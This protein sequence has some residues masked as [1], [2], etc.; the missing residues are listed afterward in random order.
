MARPAT[1]SVL[2]TVSGPDRPGV[3]SVLM[4]VLAQLGVELLD[5][6]QVVIRGRLTLGVLV[7]A[8]PDVEDL[9]DCVDEAMAAAGL[10]AGG[11]AVHVEAGDNTV[12]QPPSTHAV[13]VLGSPV[14]A[15]AFRSLAAALAAGARTS[16]RSAASPTIR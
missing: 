13:V 11:F 2:I 9:T 14:T 3:T 10:I 15:R 6:E 4:G 16:I 1:P 8:V 5:V 7:A 12:A